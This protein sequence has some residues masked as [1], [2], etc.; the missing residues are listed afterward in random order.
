MAQ[1]GACRSSHRLGRPVAGWRVYRRTHG[2][3]ALSPPSQRTGV[4]ARAGGSGSA[5]GG[6][7]VGRVASGVRRSCCSSLTVR[8]ASAAPANRLGVDPETIREWLRSL[9]LCGGLPQS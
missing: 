5:A 8:S 3:V 7:P 9:E 1:P 6:S 2:W 4:A